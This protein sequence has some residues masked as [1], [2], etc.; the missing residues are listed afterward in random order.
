MIGVTAPVGASAN[1][2]AFTYGT[3]LVFKKPG[4]P[5]K[6]MLEL[7]DS[8][9]GAVGNTMINQGFYLGGDATLLASFDIVNS[10]EFDI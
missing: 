2:N 6:G 3:L 9:I 1:G 10:I 7:G 4:N 5:T 8:V